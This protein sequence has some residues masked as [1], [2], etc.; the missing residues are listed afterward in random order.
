MWV[1]RVAALLQAKNAVLCHVVGDGVRWWERQQ[2][3][4]SRFHALRREKKITG[5]RVTLP[6]THT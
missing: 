5:F 1:G 2:W 6:L 4:S 3:S